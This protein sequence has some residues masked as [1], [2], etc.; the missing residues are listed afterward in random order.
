M[1]TKW[2]QHKTPKSPARRGTSPYNFVPL[3]ERIFIPDG[4]PPFHDRLQEALH[5]GRIDLLIQVRTPL[6][7][8]CAYPPKH[9]GQAVNLAR[10]KQEFYH[11]GDNGDNGQ[12]VIPGSSLRGALR[13]LVNVIGYG[14]ISRRTKEKG[15][16]T[17]I[18]DEPLIYR[19]VGDQQTPAG[20]EYHA[21]FGGGGKVQAGYLR[22]DG[23]GWAIR[24]A[25]RHGGAQFTRVAI[26]TL[27]FDGVNE[28]Q[29]PVYVQPGPLSAAFSRRPA[30]GLVEGTLV[31]AG[32]MP[33]RQ[34]HTV[35]YAPD[36]QAEQI[37]IPQEIWERFTI[38]QDLKRGIPNRKL[39][40]EGAPCFY[41]LDE[42]GKLFFVG[43]TLFF[44]VPYQKYTADFVPQ[45]QMQGG[46]D[47]SERIFGT[48]LPEPLEKDG[49]V[50]YR[51][52]VRLDDAVMQKAGPSGPFL[53]GAN[54]G[55]RTPAILSA[56]KPTS[57]QSYLVQTDEHGDR[58]K[59]HGYSAETPAK[60]VLRGHK[61]YFH[62]GEPGMDLSEELAR[63]GDTQR[64]IIR[65]VAPGT[66]FR[67]C[68]RFENLSDVELGALLAALEL[69]AGCLHQLGMGKPHGLG[70]VQI[71]PTVMLYSPGVRY[72]SL[73]STG[74]LP[75]DQQHARLEK[76]RAAFREA[77][78]SHYNG[79]VQQQSRIGADKGIW[80]IPRLGELRRLLDFEGRPE[81]AS[82]R[83]M[84]L[85]D[86]R[87]RRVLPTPAG[88]KGHPDPD[89]SAIL[90]EGPSGA[91]PPRQAPGKGP[92]KGASLPTAAPP[93]RDVAAPVTKTGKI[94]LFTYS[95]VQLLFDGEPTKRKVPLD[96]K[97]FPCPPWG[98]LDGNNLRQG[99]RV[100]VTLRDD[101][102]VSVV[103]ADQ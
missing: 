17:R 78:V 21:R 16:A 63:P 32:E 22:R 39:D 6:Y 9:E 80:D 62:R 27:G 82:T 52:R 13:A 73:S 59:L 102:V 103:P 65:P 3:A 85:G 57:F 48:V 35:I 45:A 79:A 29:G 10:S 41:L 64:T 4:D 95:G 100:L 51:G 87:D 71:T 11:H 18:L 96:M 66:V 47:L 94:V 99:R 38:D 36:P 72:A 5:H 76:A 56:P 68:L 20:Q 97:I 53:G 23:A 44:R 40:G 46:L 101:K 61:R 14:R 2:P 77:I 98:R 60:T 89:V 8:R 19:T 1:S 15:S 33:G 93:P 69:P 90:E 55:R 86:F 74:H 49:Q 26:T 84:G 30:P 37:R 43:P 81:R 25:M 24:P 88:V 75:A 28:I 31:F 83:Y 70:S 7:T 42:G 54:E 12:P 91:A 92:Q 67:G 58:R 34:K 50:A